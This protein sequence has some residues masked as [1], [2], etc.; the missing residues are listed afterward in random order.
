MPFVRISL[1][2]TTLAGHKKKISEAV[3]QALIDEF[4][5]SEGDYFHVVDESLMALN[6]I[7]HKIIWV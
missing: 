1:L 4:N 7:I 3:H 6:Y 2:K 5:V